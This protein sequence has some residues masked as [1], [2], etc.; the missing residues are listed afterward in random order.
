[1]RKSEG[2]KLPDEGV[3]MLCLGIVELSIVFFN[4]IRIF[5]DVY[6]MQSVAV[7][8]NILM[9]EYMLLTYV[10]ILHEYF[11]F[12]TIFTNVTPTR[13]TNETNIFLLY[14]M[15]WLFS[16]PLGTLKEIIDDTTHSF[17]LVVIL[18]G[19]TVVMAKYYLEET[20]DE[21]GGNEESSSFVLKDVRAKCSLIIFATC[22]LFLICCIFLLEKNWYYHI[23]CIGLNCI[24]NVPLQSFQ[25]V[26]IIRI[27]FTLFVRNFSPKIVESF[28]V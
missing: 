10:Y 18:I 6:S 19:L 4:I 8:V 17:I 14:L 1:M 20:W 25:P 15:T 24:R 2:N 7:V 21:F 9:C 12:H 3:L 13:R 28:E 22:A 11:I 26:I 16:T 23:P 27:I 5:H